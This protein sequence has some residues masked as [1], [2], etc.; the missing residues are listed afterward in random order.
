[1]LDM[2]A[3]DPTLLPPVRTL[4]LADSPDAFALMMRAGHVGKLVALPAHPI[5]IRRDGSYLVTGGLGGL[6]PEIAVW[7]LRQGAGGV[8]RLGRHA[9]VA[10]DDIVGGDVTDPAAL[11][12]VDAHL[13]ARGLP[14]LRGV[15]HAAGVLEDGVVASLDPGSFDRVAS[16]KLLGLRA[17]QSQWPDLEL[18]VG[19]SSA[20]ALFGSAGQA[21]HTAASAALD[22]EIAAMAAAGRPAVTVDW[23]AWRDHGAAAA[24]GATASLGAGMGTIATSEGFAALD[25][26]L[27]SGVPHAAVLPVNR[28]AMRKAGIEPPLLRVAGAAPEVTTAP[29]VT[30]GP[31]EVPLADRR[32]WLQQ[33]VAEECAAMLAIRGAIEPR[34]PLNELGLDSLAALELR[35]RLGRLAGAVL[36][37]SLLFDYPTVASLVDYLARTHF[38]L[39]VAAV[40]REGDLK[41]MLIAED[42]V[43]E[44]SDAELDAALSA[45]VALHGDGVA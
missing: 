5:T 44:A 9:T 40:E 35:N 36:P 11:R 18:L 24:R 10:A 21:A 41:D 34:R 29:A 8:V 17:I 37:A 39:S 13:R 16:P 32:A 20:G 26:V 3:A 1:V 33:R 42:A 15:I 28:I 38:G 27:Q 7:L 2:V 23:G 4:P 31:V 43:D 14:Q 30:H 25:K 19:F 45:F 6:G 12:A 22:A